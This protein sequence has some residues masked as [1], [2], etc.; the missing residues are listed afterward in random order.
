MLRMRIE[1]RL[2][3]RQ[4]FIEC[5]NCGHD[6]IA[7]NSVAQYCVFCLKYA[8]MDGCHQRSRRD[9]SLIESVF[10]VLYKTDPMSNVELKVV[11]DNQTVF[12]IC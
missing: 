11:S 1:K 9:I 12:R 8:T 2:L 6:P 7:K 4:L 3:R 10:V 5:P